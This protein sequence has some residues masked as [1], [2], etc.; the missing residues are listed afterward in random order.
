MLQ[1]RNLSTGYGNKQ[2]L[3][4]VTIEVMAGEIVLL[5]GSNGSGKSTVL[6][7]IYGLLPRFAGGTG[8]IFVDGENVTR[9]ATAQLIR[10]GLVYVPQKN[11]CFDNLSVK[12]NLEVGTLTLL[13]SNARKRAIERCLENLPS[14]RANLKKYPYQLSGGER[15]LL[16]LAIA[17]THQPKVLLLDEPL[18]G[19][20]EQ[21]VE[22][23]KNQIVQLNQLGGVSILIVEHRIKEVISLTKSVVGLKL[24]RVQSYSVDAGFDTELFKKVFM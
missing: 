7:A 16:A 11:N 24:G 18:A 14:L 9:C 21:H 3:F 13:H 22:L 12:E 15:Q 20:A 4:E 8:E 19:L 2:V 23:V 1:V 17:I 10:K 5:I 6:K